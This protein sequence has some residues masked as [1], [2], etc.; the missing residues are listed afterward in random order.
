MGVP[1][2]VFSEQVKAVVVLKPGQRATEDEIREFCA[3]HL[4]DYKVPK[5][6]EFREVLPRNPGGKV[7]KKV[8][9]V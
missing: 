8:L 2:K 6:V 7:D 4:A 1:N 3:K 9:K 5:Y